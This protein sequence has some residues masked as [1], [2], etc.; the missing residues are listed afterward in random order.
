[1]GVKYPKNLLKSVRH[2]LKCPA[3]LPN[4][5]G[6]S[7]DAIN[8]RLRDISEVI[9]LTL[10]KQVFWVRKFGGGLFWQQTDV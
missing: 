4:T 5:A 6:R 10:G 2:Y 1:M 8:E 9:P 7:L 3:Y